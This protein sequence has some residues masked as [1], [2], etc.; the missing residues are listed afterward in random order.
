MA[1]YPEV[2]LP[3]PLRAA[4]ARGEWADAFVLLEGGTSA[5][6]PP[7]REVV[8]A[9]QGRFLS[10]LQRGSYAVLYRFEK[11]PAV[12]LRASP[13]ALDALAS[14]PGVKSVAPIE[15][16]SAALWGSVPQIGGDALY[17][18]GYRGAGALVAVLDTGIDASHPDIAG[19]VAG[20]ECFC[21]EACCPE[22][23][24]R[25]SGP[26]SAQSKAS[27]GPHVTG[28]IA[29][30]GTIAGRGVAPEATILAIRVLSD[31][32]RGLIMDWLAALD[33][34][35][36][37][38][39]DVNA[40][41]MSLVSDLKFEGECSDANPYGEAF[42]TLLAQFRERGIPVVAASGNDG[43]TD[44]L[45]MPACIA[46]SIAVGAVD[47]HDSI[48]ASS[49]T[50][51]W[52]D[53][54]A[55]GVRIV[56]DVPGG[57]VLPLSGTSMA[58]AHVTGAVAALLPLVP[59]R[60]ADV[61]AEIFAATGAPIVDQRR[62][63]GAS[64]PV[65]PRIDARAALAKLAATPSFHP[66]GGNRE[67][68]CYAEWRVRGAEGIPWFRAARVRCTDG[69]TRCDADTEP[70]QC[71]FTVT[72]C[73]A[74]P[75]PRLPACDPRRAISSYLP[76]GFQERRS[77]NPLDTENFARFT[78]SLPPLPVGAPATCGPPF[79]FVVRTR[80]A[81]SLRLLAAAGPRRD[82]DRLRL[83]CLPAS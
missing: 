28:I 22:G 45:P 38:R 12:T 43:D 31:W 36:A 7:G 52:V 64:C 5:T 44:R 71:T 16:G 6:V 15:R 53:L 73:F 61:L 48:A 74:V 54:L 51:P 18:S 25:A 79:E 2:L 13:V 26:G 50:S 29:S 65:F 19:R 39:P 23:T 14:A 82:V 60:Y 69:D 56:S 41:N 47:Q 1:S 27:H 4:R 80:S 37:H 21:S 20:E 57:L 40:V 76:L 70:G 32:E 77:T 49:N 35:L 58:A 59:V 42:A 72:P 67:T 62:C 46:T 33:W 83:A 63:E 78:A 3:P 10:A 8:R 66:G 30:G 55:P 9:V 68:D 24:E 75:D 17:E 81:R 11:I 34:I